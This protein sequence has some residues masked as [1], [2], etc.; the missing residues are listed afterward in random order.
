MIVEGD[1]SV[2]ANGE[3]KGS[4]WQKSLMKPKWNIE[5]FINVLG[6]SYF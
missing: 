2:I 3:L 1:V 4:H 6:L 5:Q